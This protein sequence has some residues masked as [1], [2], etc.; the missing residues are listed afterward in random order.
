MRDI[1]QS[2]YLRSKSCAQTISVN[3]LKATR[4][5][6]L[7]IMLLIQLTSIHLQGTK[8]RVSLLLLLL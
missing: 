8:P 1:L 2:P 4:H 7:V 5:A 3:V 6:A